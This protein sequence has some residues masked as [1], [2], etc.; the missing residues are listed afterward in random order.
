MADLFLA[1]K[2]NIGRHIRNVFAER[3]SAPESVAKDSFTTT[4]D[5]KQY[6]TKRY[7]LIG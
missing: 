6:R 7:S 2:Q 5:G 3:E 4:A 1:T